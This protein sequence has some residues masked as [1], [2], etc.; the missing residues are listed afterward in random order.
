[1]VIPCLNIFTHVLSLLSIKK[2]QDLHYTISKDNVEAQSEF[3]FTITHSSWLT[4]L[5]FI[6]IT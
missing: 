4:W 6:S 1:M 5:K 2:A 3:A